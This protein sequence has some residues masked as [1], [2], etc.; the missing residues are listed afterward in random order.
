[1]KLRTLAIL[2]IF[3]A[4]TACSPTRATIETI[5]DTETPVPTIPTATFMPP[6]PTA[7]PFLLG[8]TFQPKG[9]LIFGNGEI[10]NFFVSKEYNNFLVQTNLG[11]FLYDL[12]SLERLAF[13]ETNF[14]V[15]TFNGEEG[16]MRIPFNTFGID[17]KDLSKFYWDGK[18]FII[19]DQM[20]L[21]DVG[22]SNL[23]LSEAAISS[24][25]GYIL[26]RE[27]TRDDNN[28][29]IM[30]SRSNVGLW[31]EANSEPT[32]L[33]KNQK[34]F[35]YILAFSPD[36]KKIS[37]LGDYGGSLTSL[38]KQNV[39]L[40]DI[41]DEGLSSPKVIFTHGERSDSDIKFS[42]D[43]SML[44]SGDCHGEVLIYNIEDRTKT[45]F[46]LGEKE[47]VN[48]IDLCIQQVGFIDNNRAAVTSNSGEFVILTIDTGG[49]EVYPISKDSI[50]YFYPIDNDT[51]IFATYDTV[52][53]FT[54]SNQKVEILN[55]DFGPHYSRNT[56]VDNHLA[57]I[58]RFGNGQIALDV[59]DLETAT[60]IKSS[61]IEVYYP[62]FPQIYTLQD[63]SILIGSATG[64]PGV[65]PIIQIDSSTW[66]IK[67]ANL[68]NTDVSFEFGLFYSKALDKYLAVGSNKYEI[69][70]TGSDD[71]V[72]NSIDDRK[73]TL[74][75]I[76]D[77]DINKDGSQIFALE[78]NKLLQVINL[79]DP[80][81]S[82]TITSSDFRRKIVYLGND[83]ILTYGFYYWSIQTIHQI[84]T[85]IL[86]LK[87][88]KIED[89][90]INF[91]DYC[92]P[93]K[94]DSDIDFPDDWVSIT[95][96]DGILIYDVVSDKVKENFHFEDTL[97]DDHFY[98][99]Y[100][101]FPKEGY[102]LGNDYY[103][104]FK[105]MKIFSFAK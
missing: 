55:S 31:K 8:D 54:L 82:K 15:I 14:K 39:Y 101:F 75:E 6:T 84:E 97:K 103:G 80:N 87:T 38:G 98:W 77:L 30:T 95:Y 67:Q 37:M 64:V 93:I 22:G 26:G 79:V 72:F 11:L 33:L 102:L 25:H 68:E 100:Y 29:W 58:H 7:N 73:K 48:Y 28:R 18:N 32:I 27:D 47:D 19:D 70:L 43:S 81:L 16:Y 60:K 42:S 61:V 62:E 1:M 63:G 17:A 99:D 50:K 71:P 86:D 5:E 2:I 46:Q 4:S 76:F 57:S 65:H 20:V 13:K 45:V 36:E 23:V 34:Y 9:G 94:I 69:V 3:L 105:V 96:N 12:T 88:G 49:R 104:F 78:N 53:K 91:P 92:E 59:W 41:T 51:I 52:S 74:R 10:I 83:Q 66:E 85:A 90:E 21:L 24:K 40:A 35:P 89:I 56:I 44:I